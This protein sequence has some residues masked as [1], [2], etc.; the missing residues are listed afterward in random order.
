M[1]KNCSSLIVGPTT[2]CTTSG[3]LSPSYGTPTFAHIVSASCPPNFIGF[4][5]RLVLFADAP[6][7]SSNMAVPVRT[8]WNKYSPFDDSSPDIRS[9]PYPGRASALIYNV[10]CMVTKGSGRKVWMADGINCIWAH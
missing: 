7:P 2:A 9:S 8:A 4:P 1:S 6:A 5:A 10:K 3:K